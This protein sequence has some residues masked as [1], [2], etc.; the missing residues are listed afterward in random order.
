MNDELRGALKK[1]VAGEGF[2]EG[3]EEEL[4]RWKNGQ[5]ISDRGAIFNSSGRTLRP[6][7]VSETG[8]PADDWHPLTLMEFFGVA[9]LAEEWTRVAAAEVRVGNVIIRPANNTA[10]PVTGIW[11][12]KGLSGVDWYHYEIKDAGTTLTY[13]SDERVIVRRW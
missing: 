12:F 13:R 11:K 10:W 7:E 9:H 5:V 3:A 6:D 4:D 1:A 2:G 8:Y